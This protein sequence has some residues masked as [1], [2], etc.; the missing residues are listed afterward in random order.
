MRFRQAVASS[1]KADIV[2]EVIVTS[3]LGLVPRE[4]ELFY[5][6][7]DY[8]IPVTGHWDSDEKRMAEDMVSWLVESQGYDMVVSHLG[9]EREPVNSVLKDFVDTSE[10]HPG[11]AESLERLSKTL[12]ESVLEPE[13]GTRISRNLED[14]RSLCRFQ[15]GEAGN[16]LCEGSKIAGKWPYLKILSGR[17]QL[18]MLTGERGMVSLTTLGAKR[19]A[20]AGAYS[21]E[22]EDFV[23]KG[24]LFAVGIERASPEIRIGDD[25]AV[26][27][28]GDVRAVGVARMSPVEMELAERGEAVHIRHVA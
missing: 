7:Q 21:V 11:S 24:N 1:G 20:D 15:F 14:M 12:A 28:S 8:D 26:V 16:A 9:D 4:L 23:P 10:G 17:E 22:I 5:P 25:V 27:H 6:A 13:S 2:H 3:P 18:G 19:I